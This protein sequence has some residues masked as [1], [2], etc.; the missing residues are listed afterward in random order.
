[1]GA[2]ILNGTAAELDDLLDDRLNKILVEAAEVSGVS[3]LAIAG[4]LIRAGKRV[5]QA[6]AARDRRNGATLQQLADAAGLTSRQAAR[7]KFHASDRTAVAGRPAA[8]AARMLSLSKQTIANSYGRYGV[9]LKTHPTR[10]GGRPIK[11]YFLP[12]DEGHSSPPQPGGDE[13]G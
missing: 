8:E 13:P 12:G 9:E 1:M 2:K 10:P 5:E 7:S 3:E 4:Q 6:L 11:R